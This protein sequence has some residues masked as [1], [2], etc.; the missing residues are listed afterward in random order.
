MPIS[1]VM[2]SAHTLQAAFNPPMESSF[3]FEIVEDE[4]DKT[5]NLPAMQL[6]DVKANTKL[7]FS[8]LSN[9]PMQQLTVEHAEGFG[10]VDALAV[11]VQKLAHYDKQN[12][13]I[14]RP[15]VFLFVQVIQ[16]VW[17]S[18]ANSPELIVSI[19]FEDQS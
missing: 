19:L 11:C 14:S 10:D 1:N 7:F 15:S 2:E 18:S 4:A 8:I 9:R 5:N 17:N 16:V 12:K 3:D 6:V 13:V